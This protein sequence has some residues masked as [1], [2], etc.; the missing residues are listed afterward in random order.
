MFEAVAARI[1]REIHA[2]YRLYPGNYIAADLLEDEKRFAQHYSDADVRTFESYLESR[3]ALIDLPE[4]DEP[5][6]R[7][8]LLTMY[9][10]PLYN[11]L[12]AHEK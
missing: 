2:R 5:Y 11:Y 10:N 7:Q 12:K 3:L 6:L 4:K 1:D 8:C 9:A